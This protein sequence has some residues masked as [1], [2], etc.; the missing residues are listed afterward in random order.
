MSLF[1]QKGQFCH[2]SDLTA[3]VFVKLSC[4]FFLD[5]SNSS[6]E[7]LSKTGVFL[8][9]IYVLTNQHLPIKKVCIIGKFPASSTNE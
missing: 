2:I 9:K 6:D 1:C 7:S 4:S 3:S 8:K 5:A